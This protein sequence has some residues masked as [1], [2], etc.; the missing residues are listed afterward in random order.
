MKKLPV[1]KYSENF[2]TWFALLICFLRPAN[3]MVLVADFLI[4]ELITHEY[5]TG[6]DEESRLKIENTYI[7]TQE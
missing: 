7:K 1:A 6:Q 2:L 4:T 5:I 3:A